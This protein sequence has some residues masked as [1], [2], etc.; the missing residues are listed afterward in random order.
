MDGRGTGLWS[1]DNDTYRMLSYV[2][3]RRKGWSL[4]PGQWYYRWPGKAVAAA[5]PNLPYGR[6]SAK[7]HTDRTVA[8]ISHLVLLGWRGGQLLGTM[9]V[10]L[11]GSTTTQFV[12]EQDLQSRPCPMCFLR[13]DG[14]GILIQNSIVVIGGRS[15]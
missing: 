10:W 11:C 9:A 2:A 14:L 13:R 4:Q 12:L 3:N 6:A 8:H 15:G 7:P 1:R 5:L